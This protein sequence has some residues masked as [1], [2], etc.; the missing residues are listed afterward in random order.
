MRARFRLLSLIWTVAATLAATV[1]AAA[2]DTSDATAQ[3]PLRTITFPVVGRSHYSDTFGAPRSG[4]RSHAGA[5]VMADKMQLLVATVNGT[6]SRVTIPEPSYGYMLTITDDEGWSYN[7]IH[8]NNDTPGTDDG[9]APLDAVFAPGI[10]KGARVEPGQLVGYVG[11]SGNAEDVAPQLHFEIVDPAGVAVN[12]TPS[13][14]AAARVD[15]PAPP[16]STAGADASAPSSEPLARF[17]GADRA[18]TAIAVSRAVWPAGGTA[19]VVVANGSS[20]AEAL[21]ASV[22]AAR[23]RSPLLLWRQANDAALLAELDRLGA[24]TVTAVGSVPQ[25]FELDLSRVGVTVTRVGAPGDP[26]A[27]AAAIAARLAPASR[28][29]MVNAERFA[30]GVAAASLAAAS[31]WPVL[32]SGDIRIPQ[33]TVDAWRALGSPPVTVL[34]GTRVI[35]DKV[36]AFLQ[37]DRL[38]GADRYETAVAAAGASVELGRPLRELVV[39]TGTAFPDA[40]AAAALA[41]QKRG[42]TVLVDGAG[43]GADSSVRSWLTSRRREIDEVHVLGGPAAVSVQAAAALAASLGG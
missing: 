42:V 21:P 4:G 13:L 12:P 43:G 29:V 15:V 35:S 20:Y 41:A 3:A 24:R 18:A 28:V 36:Q 6:V 23:Y 2:A 7:Y 31:G 37:A 10:E 19:N 34:G 22:L 1:P 33:V 14:D 25:S 40:L 26:S 27:T 39:A 32:L 17:A 8:I 5:D 38:A 16:A 30:D 11:D 9:Q